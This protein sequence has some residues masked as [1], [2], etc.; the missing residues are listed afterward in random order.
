MMKALFNVGL[1]GLGLMG[2]ALGTPA[3]GIVTL[4]I[5]GAEVTRIPLNVVV[6]GSET[7][8]C[9]QARRHL[10]YLFGLL[11]LFEPRADARFAK[12]HIKL[13]EGKWKLGFQQLQEMLIEPTSFQECHRESAVNFV[14]QVY[15]KI[16]G[17]P[18]FFN[19]KVAFVGEK[20]PAKARVKNLYIANVDGS[21]VEQLVPTKS[22]V[23]FPRFSPSGKYLSFISFEHYPGKGHRPELYVLEVASRKLHRIYAKWGVGIGSAV[24]L[25]PDE[26]KLIVSLRK[27]DERGLF[28][29]SMDKPDTEQGLQYRFGFDVEPSID[30]SG[31]LL[32]F[33]SLRTGKPM[34]YTLPLSAIHRSEVPSRLTFVGR[35]NSTPTFSSDGQWIVFGGDNYDNF[36]LFK[37]DPAG[38]LLFRLTQTA[39]NEESPFFSPYSPK[40]LIFSKNSPYGGSESSLHMMHVDFPGQSFQ[41]K[42]SV[43]TQMVFK[44]PTWSGQMPAQMFQFDP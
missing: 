24:F 31:T 40:H 16:S 26:R 38:N 30:P 43:S 13:E 41:I 23:M 2:G 27:G 21:Q 6:E 11:G 1:L 44:T 34:V 15:Q 37:I 9:H 33:S 19:A 29:V 5:S 25:P 39:W 28:L 42:L 35:Y 8:R 10:E 32:T 17:V 18:N 22:F 36:D 20:G 12:V 4:N 3:S 14:G 7:L